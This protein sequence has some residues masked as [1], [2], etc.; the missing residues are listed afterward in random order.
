MSVLASVFSVWIGRI[1]A[2]VHRID[3]CMASTTTI[4]PVNFCHAAEVDFH[5]L[6]IEHII[7][8]ARAPDAAE[9][10]CAGKPARGGVGPG[11]PRRRSTAT[12]TALPE[13][14]GPS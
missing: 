7:S 13:G 14:S 5:S 11:A 8:F 3:H 12:M 4:E 1:G 6:D 9:F 2:D 10:V